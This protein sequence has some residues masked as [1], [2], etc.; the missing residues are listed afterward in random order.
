[1]LLAGLVVAYALVYAPFWT[2]ATG[3]I[4]AMWVLGPGLAYLCLH[5][6]FR[7]ESKFFRGLNRPD[8]SS[9]EKR[10]AW[11]IRGL[12]TLGGVGFIY[13][14]VAPVVVGCVRLARGAKLTP[15]RASVQHVGNSAKGTWF[16]AQQM[17]LHGDSVD[18]S[19]YLYL[20]LRVPPRVGQE[21]DVTLIPGS[22]LIACINCPDRR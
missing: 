9:S 11:Y 18:G 4:L 12:F 15:S 3:R 19:Y 5:E 7:N 13:F 8:A 21:I 10:S 20:S 16:F 2:E 1:M 6:A 17:T 22:H 14:M